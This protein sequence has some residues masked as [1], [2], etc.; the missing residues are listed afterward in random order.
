MQCVNG[1]DDP[2]NIPCVTEDNNLLD[3]ARVCDIQLL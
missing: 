1:E 3:G 2:A